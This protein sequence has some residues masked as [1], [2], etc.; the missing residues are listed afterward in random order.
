ML[1]D[2]RLVFLLDV[3]NTLLDNDRFAADL[4]TRLEQLLGAAERD[5][6]W[7]IYAEL[8]ETLGYADYLASLQRLRVG[9]EDPPTCCRC[10]ASCSNI[11]SRSVCTS[12]RST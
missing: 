8:K 4:S 12:R 11:P 10:R 1:K 2:E 3:D 5:R 9:L 7:L 6:Y